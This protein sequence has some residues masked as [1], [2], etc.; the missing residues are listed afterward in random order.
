M[1]AARALNRMLANKTEVPKPFLQ[2]LDR[3]K[4]IR[5]GLAREH[6]AQCPLVRRIAAI[7]T[8][9]AEGGACRRC[10]SGKVCTLP[11]II[12]IVHGVVAAR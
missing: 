10:R 5:S 4:H 3:S 7:V 9:A 11:E 1:N 8:I 2:I 12:A 6:A